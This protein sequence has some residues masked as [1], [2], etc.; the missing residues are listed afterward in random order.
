MN[1]IHLHTV[2]MTAYGNVKEDCDLDA[3]IIFMQ[4]YPSFCGTLFCDKDKTSFLIKIYVFLVFGISPPSSDI[5]IVTYDVHVSK[6]IHCI[7]L[8]NRYARLFPSPNN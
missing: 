6:N 7:A 5:R 1:Y 8:Y 2:L 3:M 4:F